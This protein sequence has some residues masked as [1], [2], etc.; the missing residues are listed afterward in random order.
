MNNKQRIGLAIGGGVL[1]VAAAVGVGAGAANLAGGSTSAVPGYGQGPNGGYGDHGNGMDT[2]AMA[3]A[4]A[5]KLG[6][7]ESKVKT[8]LDNAMK[9]NRPSGG[10][11][12]AGN[13]GAGGSRPTAAANP[14]SAPNNTTMLTAMAKSIATELKLNQST[15]LTALTEVWSTNGPGAGNAPTA[16]PTS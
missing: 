1:A 16:K 3:K 4:L 12:A 13:N 15:V 5:T 10:P 14:G 8:A 9:A 7:D 11:T 6:V 2:T